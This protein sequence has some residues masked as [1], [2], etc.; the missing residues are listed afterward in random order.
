MTD[1]DTGKLVK[2]NEKKKLSSI[3][4][5]PDYIIPGVPGGGFLVNFV[6]MEYFP[7]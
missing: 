4:C 5:Q 2:V 6:L 1:D 3:L 7:D